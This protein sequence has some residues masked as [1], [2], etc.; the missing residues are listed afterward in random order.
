[1][2]VQV[3]LRDQL[4]E[5]TTDGQADEN[6]TANCVPA[7]LSAAL[8]YYT[9][10][11]W[12][13]DQL[14][15]AVYGQGYTGATDPEA[16]I[17]W[18]ADH[19]VRMWK[20]V[21][22]QD[23]LVQT[24]IEQVRLGHAVSGAIPSQWGAAPQADP[25]HQ[26]GG[27]H[28]VTFCDYDATQ[29]TLT[30]MNPWPINGVATGFYQTMPVS[31]WVP[32]IV[33]GRIF[34]LM[35]SASMWTQQADGWFLDSQ[36]HRAG[37]GAVGWIESN[38]FG[39]VDALADESRYSG[40][41]TTEYANLAL[42][43]GR[44]V[45]I[46]RVMENGVEVYS[47]STE[48]AAWVYIGEEAAH[49]ALQKQVADLTQQEAQAQQAAQSAQQQATQAQADAHTAQAQ[50]T[51]LQGQLSAAEQHATQ[52]QTEADAQ[53]H[54]AQDAEAALTKAQ[55]DA[56]AQEATLQAQITSLQQQLASVPTAIPVSPSPVAAPSSGF[57]AALWRALR[58]IFGIGSRPPS[59]PVRALSFVSA[60]GPMHRN[61]W[62]RSAL[63]LNL[64]PDQRA[65]LRLLKNAAYSGILT[66]G[67]AAWQF[68]SSTAY[69]NGVVSWGSVNWGATALIF[70]G[71]IA[72]TVATT[73]DKYFTAHKEPLLSAA[74]QTVEQA[75]QQAMPVAPV[76]PTPA[77]A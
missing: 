44:L 34:P 7:S 9:G 57:L 15:D 48:L 23:Q 68:V 64:N 70:V 71:G 45:T 58:Q 33:Y 73:V 47:Y 60:G 29:Q 67:L 18:L 13:G 28:Q 65:L 52:L 56:T 62:K 37:P 39:D 75:I 26:T 74:T 66:A 77:A 54:A 11:T 21:G 38:G 72:L 49:T 55:A 32:R 41:G 69:R 17:P 6:A 12:Y 59:A 40:D 30:A 42:A 8:S 50:A 10:Q 20:Y 53:A 61:P 43:N 4:N 14:K 25:V 46:K 76:A 2:L 63:H 35:R 19:G 16:Y 1:M 3:P 36:G 51:S 27:T 31:W 5:P 24:I 22:S